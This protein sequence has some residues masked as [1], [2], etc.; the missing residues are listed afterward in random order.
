MWDILSY[1]KEQSHN[2]DRHNIITIIM[3]QYGTDVQDAIH[4][5]A[6]YHAALVR[7]FKETSQKE[8]QWGGVGAVDAQG[9]IDALGNW[10]YANTLWSFESERYF[11]NR[12]AEIMDTRI[13]PLMPQAKAES[14]KL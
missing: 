13:I 11:G 9:F 8:P 5:A 14:I 12:G 4:W 7:E 3:N 6:G 10:V 1:S 2:D